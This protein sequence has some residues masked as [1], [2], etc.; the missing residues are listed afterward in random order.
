MRKLRLAI[1]KTISPEPTQKVKEALTNSRVQNSYGE[2]L[3]S[4]EVQERL[5]EEDIRRKD[6]KE[7]PKKIVKQEDIKG[8]L[9]PK[10]LFE[11]AV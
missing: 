5:K 11:K 8:P 4:D 7:L 2:V 3:T 6:K 10:K 1:L 9:V